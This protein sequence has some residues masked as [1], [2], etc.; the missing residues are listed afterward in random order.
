MGPFDPGSHCTKCS[1]LRQEE[2]V[3]RQQARALQGLGR[4][5]GFFERSEGDRGR[6]TRS[7]ELIEEAKGG[8][9]VYGRRRGADPPSNS[10]R[11]TASSG[12]RNSL[13]T[14]GELPSKQD[15]QKAAPGVR[16]DRQPSTEAGE[17]TKSGGEKEG[18]FAAEDGQDD[19]CAVGLSV[20]NDYGMDSSEFEAFMEIFPEAEAFGYH[21]QDACRWHAITCSH[22]H[23]L[24]LWL[25][26]HDLQK[27]TTLTAAIGKWTKLEL[28][29]INNHSLNTLPDEL[30]KLQCLRELKIR[31]NPLT[32]LPDT[33]CQLSGLENLELVN[34]PLRTLPDCIHQ[35]KGLKSLTLA[36]SP[37]V[38]ALPERLPMNLRTLNL[39]FDSLQ[40]LPSSLCSLQLT[41]LR[42]G[43][44]RLTALPDCIGHM[45][46]LLNL[47]AF[48]NRL[49]SIPSSCALLQNLQGLYLQH[50]QL[51]TVPEAVCKLPDLR[52]LNLGRNNLT[53]LPTCDLPNLRFMN[54]VEN[55]L[56]RV[57]DWVSILPELTSMQLQHNK[58]RQLP[59]KWD[60]PVLKFLNLFGNELTS[61]PEKFFHGMESLVSLYLASNQLTDLPEGLDRL[62]QLKRHGSTR[63]GRWVPPKKGAEPRVGWRL[64]LSKNQ[65]MELPESLCRLNASLKYLHAYSNQFTSLPNALGE[66]NALKR[67]SLGTNQLT[68]LPESMGQ[69]R[70]L[71]QLTLRNNRLTTLP[72]SLGQLKN[73]TRLH[74]AH[75]QL[76]ELPKSLGNATQLLW[77]ALGNN[78]LSQLPDSLVQLKSLQYLYLESNDLQSLP[79]DL[80]NLADMRFL[81]LQN[82]RLYAL[83]E[84][85]SS[86]TAL[87][88]L[89][90]QVNE[91]RSLPESFH[92]MK[93]L[94]WLYVQANKLSSLPSSWGS[95]SNLQ[96]LLAGDNQLTSLPD[97]PEIPSSLRLLHLKN[98]RLQHLPES[99][100]QMQ[101]LQHLKL[102]NNHLD[103]LPE[104]IGELPNLQVLELQENRLTSL[105][106]S[107]GKL[108]SLKYLYAQKN[109]L[110]SIPALTQLSGLKVLLLHQNSISG[111]LKEIC[112]LASAQ[113]IYLHNNELTGLIPSCVRHLSSLKA[114]TLHRNS[115]SGQLPEEL[116]TLSS[117]EMLTL[118]MNFLEGSIPLAFTDA[119]SLG[120][121]TLYSNQ[122]S[123]QVPPLN[124]RPTCMD[125]L[126]FMVPAYRVDT[127]EEVELTCNSHHHTLY[128]EEIQWTSFLEEQLA[129]ACPKSHGTCQSAS[130]RGPVL[131]L[132]SNRL[133]CALPLRMTLESGPLRSLILFG[134]MLGDGLEALPSWIHERERQPFLYVS[135]HTPT[136]LLLLI[137]LLM[138]LFIFGARLTLGHHWLDALMFSIR[139]FFDDGQDDGQDLTRRSHVFLLKMAGALSA[140]GFFLFAL[141]LKNAQYYECGDSFARTTFAYF[142]SEDPHAE[143]AVSCCW[144]FW[145]LL[146]MYSLRLLPQAS[147]PFR[148]RFSIKP[149]SASPSSGIW[150]ALRIACCGGLWA[151]IVCILS[152]PSLAYTFANTL[153]RE[154]TLV[155]NQ[156]W[157]Q[158]SHK[159]AALAMLSVDLII[160][161]R[162]AERFSR[163]ANMRRSLLLMAARLATMWLY[164]TVCAIVLNEQCMRGWTKFWKVC[165]KASDSYKEFNI[166]LGHNYLLNPTI[167]LCAANGRWS[168]H[169]ACMRSVIETLAPLFLQKILQRA[170]I[171]PVMMFVVWAFSKNVE[172]K[173][174][175]KS[176]YFP[177]CTSR[178][179]DRARQGSL[180]VTLAEL[181]L[182]WGAFVPLLLP[183][184]LLAT[185]TNLM[186]F[187]LGQSHF[188]AK[189]P[190]LRE[191]DDYRG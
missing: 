183:A 47:N 33:L 70:N 7:E 6:G 106:S 65:L 155:E 160:T 2:R 126:S 37:A 85:I 80:G 20:T 179:L 178:G 172:G 146:C 68:S 62:Q 100:S 108:M 150:R 54:L 21:R 113:V 92:Q 44:N 27:K 13:T 26:K 109:R 124:L 154:N 136:Q 151:C 38:E 188:K 63:P 164:A 132:Q 43:G 93:R 3:V 118:H 94:R 36:E 104:S 176:T 180:L 137:A 60:L 187:R 142:L 156:A 79:A 184:V 173:L 141:H 29:N 122:I 97:T 128:R 152:L 166:T 162:L 98:N 45:T 5:G 51:T 110:Q 39:K 82:N 88:Y 53:S 84:S 9:D 30:S 56:T 158:F 159:Q 127:Q 78:R 103:V 99:L 190:E 86:M 10:P 41:H 12:P 129:E 101:S 77:L 102:Q 120:F 96:E 177:I 17:A 165:D 64:E 185:T 147:Q 11:I 89:M 119:P 171:Q 95:L 148:E 175:L 57:P 49:T 58:L 46:S 91:L 105:P 149:P 22:G 40:F 73:L 153:P 14:V 90:V 72:E 134:N 4:G 55:Q 76:T 42:L 111:N 52:M 19:A 1:Q 115:L 83:P 25:S 143:L 181:A 15:R 189:V 23:V 87:V 16:G 144:C 114:L 157:L 75:N 163:W 117:L 48:S 161:Q 123:G 131:L 138:L 167:D 35:L 74:L 121:L 112:A 81:K 69:L 24:E 191:T 107:L 169:G 116:A 174:I 28:I 61:L 145:A 71:E 182:L 186:V 130:S 125:D 50:N 133:S 8:L 18:S 59:M 140:I 31:K 66:L 170:F 168:H 139:N 135:S 32:S 34:L 67:L